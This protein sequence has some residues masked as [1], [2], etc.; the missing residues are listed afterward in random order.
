MVTKE[1]E[2]KK[3]CCFYVSEYHLEMILLPYIKNNLDKYK[4]LIYTE[5]NLLESVKLLLERI[6]LSESEKEKILK[7]NWAGDALKNE[8]NDNVKKIIIINGDI[9]FIKKVNKQ[10]EKRK[11]LNIV[12]CYKVTDVNPEISSIRDN[13]DEILNTKKI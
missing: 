8:T 4:I 11:N 2:L 13:Y 7:L 5:E 12:D 9:N 10:I 3:I 6:N 1:H